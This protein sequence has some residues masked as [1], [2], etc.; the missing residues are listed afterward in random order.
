MFGALIFGALAFGQPTASAFTPLAAD[1]AIT[2]TTSPP[3]RVAATFQAAAEIELAAA[4]I[5]QSQGALYAAATLHLETVAPLLLFGTFQTQSTIAV[6]VTTSSL[7]VSG[8][9]YAAAQVSTA[10]SAALRTGQPLAA[11]SAFAV[12]A[13]GRIQAVA[14]TLGGAP[15]IHVTAVGN[16]QLQGYTATSVVVTWNGA[17]SEPKIRR[18]SLVI[19]DVLNEQPNTCSF[20]VDTGPPPAVGTDIKIGLQNLALP[21]LLF[22]GTVQKVEQRYELRAENPSWNVDCIDYTFLFNRRRVFGSW[23]NVSATTI[24]TTLVQ[25]FASSFSTAGIV[26]GLPA[27]TVTFAGDTFMDALVQLA[28]LAGAYAKV[29]YNR[30]VWLF[31]TD[32]NPSPHPIDGTPPR[33]MNLPEITKADDESQ[34]RTRIM[35][36]GKATPVVGPSES[37]IAVGS[38]EIP[39]EDATIFAP[40]GYAIADDTGQLMAY[41]GTTPGALASVVVGNVPGPS[42]AGVPQLAVGVA[43]NLSG[44]Y[45]YKVAFANSAGETMPGPPSGQIFCPDFATPTAPPGIGASGTLGP[46]AGTYGYRVAFLTTLGETLPGPVATRTA[47][48]AGSAGVPGVGVDGPGVSR[49]APG[50]YLWRSTVVTTFGESLPGGQNG[51]TQNPFVPGVPA[52][53]LQNRIADSAGGLMPGSSYTY[54]LSMLTAIGETPAYNLGTYAPSALGAPNWGTAFGGFGGIYGGPYAVGTTIVTKLG[55]SA[56]LATF[57]AATNHYTGAPTGPALAGWDTSGRVTPGPTYYWALSAFHDTYGETPL[58]G[59]AYSTTFGTTPLAFFINIPIFPANCHGLRLYRASN[60]YTYKLVAELRT[61]INQFTDRL[62]DSELGNQYPKQSNAAGVRFTHSL[63][64]SSDQGVLAR[65]VYRTRAGGGDYFLVGEVPGNALATVVD[66]YADTDL[67]QRPPTTNQTGRVCALTGLALGPSGVVGRRLYR[68]RAG[69]G[70]LFLVGELKD[71]STTWWDDPVPDSALTVS[72]PGVSTAGS[73]TKPRI[74]PALGS[75]GARARRIYRTKANGSEYFLVGE[76][77]DNSPNSFLD[78]DK[79]DEELGE[80]RLP[81][82]STAGGETHLLSGI[83][84]GPAGTLARV[85]YRTR[86]NGSEF[87]ELV[88]LSDNTTTTFTD[89]RPDDALGKGVALV[90]DAGSSAVTLTTIPIGPPSVTQRILYRTAAGTTDFRYVGTLDDNT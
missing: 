67:V 86:A 36:R 10:S 75:A 8:P 42:S 31:V 17:I 73:D 57:A 78:D 84:I 62:N 14:L 47:G 9:L 71:N 63:Y 58:S 65:R 87:Y 85:I 59:Y 80:G 6:A 28:N 45:Q 33:P 3:L 4:A 21:N 39:V 69:G 7:T 40:S 89:D 32:P 13:V 74:Y 20:I 19:T 29:D 41:S 27:V 56:I 81:T 16:A 25:T 64:P 24:A 11:A 49:L 38:T 90:N 51:Q 72:A 12:T 30:V 79:R 48:A 52:A 23:T 60:N 68:T 34:V 1:A 70:S 77:P 44:L 26:G 61:Q 18:G 50:A 35:V 46:L 66:T 76:I 43:G 22:A 82:V 2:V 54:A 5:F 37:T 53:G 55:E 83:P 88:R 15:Q